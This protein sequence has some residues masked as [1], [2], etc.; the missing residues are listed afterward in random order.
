M[1]M[2][3]TVNGRRWRAAFNDARRLSRCSVKIF[4]RRSRSVTVKKNAP[5]GIK[6]RM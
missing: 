4:R 2:A 5:P 1:T 3:S 6:A